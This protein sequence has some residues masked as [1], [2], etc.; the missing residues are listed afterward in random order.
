MLFRQDLEEQTYGKTYK[1]KNLTKPLKVRFSGLIVAI[2]MQ[3]VLI[4]SLHV[5]LHASPRASANQL[6]E[7]HIETPE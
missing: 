2:A 4:V 7:D 5:S 1:T 6:G 3:K